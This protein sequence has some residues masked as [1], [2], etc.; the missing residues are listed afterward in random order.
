M[1]GAPVGGVFHRRAGT[2]RV[3]G[4]GCSPVG[5]HRHNCFLPLLGLKSC[6][7]PAPPGT[8]QAWIP[9][10]G[11]CPLPASVLAAESQRPQAACQDPV[12]PSPKEARGQGLPSAIAPQGAVLQTGGFRLWISANIVSAQNQTVKQPMSCIEQSGGPGRRPPDL[13]TRREQKPPHTHTPRAA[14]TSQGFRQ[15]NGKAQSC[16]PRVPGNPH[17]QTTALFLGRS[18]PSFAALLGHPWHLWQQVHQLP[19]STLG[20]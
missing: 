16:P 19:V 12:W 18:V 2:S 6:P 3:R 20:D 15:D 10:D 13:S 8:Q 5:P 11:S 17:L 7:V 4:V 9:V 14:A 1:P